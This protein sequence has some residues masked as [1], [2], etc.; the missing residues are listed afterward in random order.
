MT[1]FTEYK[2]GNVLGTIYKS[3]IESKSTA[4]HIQQNV[5]LQSTID[6]KLF[7]TLN[8]HWLQNMCYEYHIRIYINM[9]QTLSK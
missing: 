7:L 1:E 5:T 6:R 9:L 2:Y 3:K 8:V 4:S